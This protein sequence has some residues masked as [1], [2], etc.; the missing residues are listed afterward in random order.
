ME[1]KKIERSNSPPKPPRR[2]TPSCPDHPIRIPHD[3]APIYPKHEIQPRIRLFPGQSPVA[4]WAIDHVPAIRPDMAGNILIHAPHAAGNWVTAPRC[5]WARQEV[6]L[7]TPVPALRALSS[8]LCLYFVD[9]GGRAAKVQ[10]WPG[11]LPGWRRWC[12][13][14]IWW[15]GLEGVD[16]GLVLGEDVFK[17]NLFV[18]VP[19]ASNL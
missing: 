5:Q 17:S 11:W 3:V 2:E 1:R 9:G 18:T 8:A 10:H 7:A 19:L 16:F 15:R 13:W 12:K 4:I 14:W 6:E